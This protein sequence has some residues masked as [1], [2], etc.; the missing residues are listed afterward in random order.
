MMPRVFVSTPC[1]VGAQIE[2]ERN[3]ARHLAL[4]LRMKPGEII[5]IVCSGNLWHARLSEISSDRV[6]T[7]IV[8]RAPHTTFEL[9]IE[10]TVLQ[11]VPKGTKMD[12][13]VEKA[14]ELGAARIVPVRCAHS[15]GG[16]SANK[17]ER[18]RRIARS[19]AQQ[20]Q[21]LIVPD[22][23]QPLRFSEAI[24]RFAAN[25]QVLV[26]HERASHGSLAA[27]LRANASRPI[28]L[29]VGPEGSFTDDE[30]RHAHEA[31]CDI[32]SLGT[33]ILRTET[34]AAAMLA[35]VA[36]LLACW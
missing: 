20:S 31:R 14:V 33:T 6:V 11:A 16:D 7:T 18:W 29:A 19:A 25:S 27:A 2:L 15:Y 3:D 9:P 23:E 10:I 5:T 35:A 8:E 24:A 28:A 17:I 21:R 34:A 26:A 32:V 36:A 1:D 4:V 12:D 13:V 22:V 30:L